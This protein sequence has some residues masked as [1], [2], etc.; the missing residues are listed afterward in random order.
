MNRDLPLAELRAYQ[1]LVPEPD[2]FD[3]FWEI[4]LAESRAAGGQ[5]TTE[6]LEL[7]LVGAAVYD[8]T[9]PGFGGEPVKAW[10]RVPASV[11]DAVPPFACV[12]QFVGY[13]GGR[14]W[15]VA[16]LTWPALGF[17][18]FRMDARGQGASWAPGDTPDPHGAGPMVPGFMT[19]GVTAPETYYYTR[20]FTD[21]A[22]AVEAAAALELVDPD[23]I[24]VVGQSQGGG[25]ALAAAAL[26]GPRVKAASVLSPFMVDIMRGVDTTDEPP[27]EEIATY[28]KT[29]PADEPSVRRTL[30]YVDGVNFARRATAPAH[31]ATGLADAITPASTVFGAYNAYAGPKEITVWPFAG[32]EGGAGQDLMDSAEFFRRHLTPA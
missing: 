8:V 20:L 5:V 22:R 30:S 14:G 7:G 28:L 25:S 15:P 32:H 2:D 31:F 9:F 13:G 17:A 18:H 24:A 26:A 12:V 19:K 3:A 6:R 10:L 23:R 1:S 29:R 21:A 16:D 4:A 27:Y 11:P